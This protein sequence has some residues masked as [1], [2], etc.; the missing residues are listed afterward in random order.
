MVKICKTHRLVLNN[1]KC[2][3]CEQERFERTAKRIIEYS[4]YGMFT[5]IS[6]L[7]PLV[8][9]NGIPVKAIIFQQN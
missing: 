7:E 2:S 4:T 1:N 9:K 5:N 8:T 3:M 6:P